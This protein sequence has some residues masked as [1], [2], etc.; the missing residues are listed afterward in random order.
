MVNLLDTLAQP[1]SQRAV[2][3][4]EKAHKPDQSVLKKPD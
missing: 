1:V 4:P 2:R 3:H